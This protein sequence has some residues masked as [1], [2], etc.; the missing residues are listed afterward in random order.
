MLERLG[1]NEW[2]GGG[3]PHRSEGERDG[4]EDMWGGRTG[5][6]PVEM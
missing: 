1:G 5:R 3:N 2:L 4:M 6:G